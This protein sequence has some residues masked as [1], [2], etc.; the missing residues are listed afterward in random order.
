MSLRLIAITRPEIAASFEANAAPHGDSK[1]SFVTALGLTAV[2]AAQPAPR[3]TFF[4]R[5]RT[6]LE[7]VEVQRILEALAAAGA[8][9]PACPGTLLEDSSEALELICAEAARLRAALDD[10][11]TTRQFQVTVKWD[12]TA[13]V[14]AI[15]QRA[16]VVAALAAAAPRG[17]L[18]AGKAL[19]AI[20][21]GEREHLARDIVARLSQLAR[22]IL[23]LPQDGE[24]CVANLVVLVDASAEE[25]FDAALIELDELLPGDS[26]I[27]C[28]GPLP[29]VSFAAVSLDRIDPDRIDAAR[30]LLKVG[31]RLNSASVRVA[32]H[33]YA[34]SHHPD[35]AEASASSGEFAAASAAYRLLRRF[36]D[37]TER[38]G[39]EP[40]LFVDILGEA[41]KGRRAA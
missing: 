29:A 36:A 24:D 14:G 18:A 4:P 1:L 6:L 10:Y 34:Q 11:G 12:A 23:V 8:V 37:Q 39:S 20:M 28:V 27:R 19:Q 26:R 30:R 32:W 16:D 41:D 21:L 25:R 33:A 9:L 17:R 13:M 35:V 5:R 40:A 38:T 7:L 31:Y 3:F 2:L 15:K 22:E